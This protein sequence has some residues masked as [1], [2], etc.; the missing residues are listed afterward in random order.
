MYC[1]HCGAMMTTTNS[2]N[3][4]VPRATCTVCK[5]V[6][7]DNPKVLVACMLFYED[8][9]LWIKR[10]T[11]PYEGRWGMPSGY[12]ECGETVEEAAS[13][14]LFEETQLI[15]AAEKFSVYGITSVPAISQI[16]ITLAAPMPSMNFQITPEVCD[17]RLASESEMAD[18]QFAYPPGVEPW[19]HTI[20]ERVRAGNALKLPAT[21]RHMPAG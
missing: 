14:E 19:V 16:Y 2:R 8:R 10:A 13:R 11:P 12:V 21:L 4:P 1:L 9:V 18:A 15:L 6:H 3:D 5:Y 20:Y 7:Y 17:I